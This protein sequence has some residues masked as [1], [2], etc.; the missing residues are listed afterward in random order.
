M[1]F[2]IIILSFN[3]NE[4]EK[5]SCLENSNALLYIYQIS[6]ADREMV[7]ADFFSVWK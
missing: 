1:Y 4:T 3:I 5:F 6:P 2:W 7:D